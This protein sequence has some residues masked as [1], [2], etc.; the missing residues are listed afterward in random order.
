M[1]TRSAEIQLMTKEEYYEIGK[2]LCKIG[3]T[4]AGR[5]DYEH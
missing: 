5:D 3:S 1:E 4:R 2:G